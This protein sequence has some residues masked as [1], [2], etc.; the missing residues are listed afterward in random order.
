MARCRGSVTIRSAVMLRPLKSAAVYSWTG[1]T[2]WRV[3]HCPGSAALYYNFSGSSWGVLH[4]P[5]RNKKRP[6]PT[7][8]FVLRD[9]FFTGITAPGAN[10]CKASSRVLHS[11]VQASFFETDSLTWTADKLSN[12]YTA[13][14]SMFPKEDPALRDGCI[15]ELLR[16]SSLYNL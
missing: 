5:G 14:D 8:R 7:E 12:M 11:C 3:V 4:Q 9:G 15:V 10:G 13:H 16:D 6:G 2:S 1:W